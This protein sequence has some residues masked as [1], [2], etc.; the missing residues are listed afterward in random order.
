MWVCHCRAVTDKHVREAIDD[1]RG[2]RDPNRSSL[3]RRYRLRLVSRRA[4]PAVRG[5]TIVRDFRVARVAFPRQRL[6]AGRKT[7]H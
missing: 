1:G 2:R 4:A 6:A 7:G 5:V 3:R